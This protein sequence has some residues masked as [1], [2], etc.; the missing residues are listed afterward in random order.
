MQIQPSLV[1]EGGRKVDEG[2][3]TVISVLIYAIVS[4]SPPIAA[5][6]VG[7]IILFRT[8]DGRTRHKKRER[9]PASN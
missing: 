7:D 4:E 2:R 9:N 6:A 1:G 5:V 3:S 8:I